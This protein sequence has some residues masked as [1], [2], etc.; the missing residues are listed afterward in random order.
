M[1]CQTTMRHF[2]FQNSI[3]VACFLVLLL[4][5]GSFLW[6]EPTDNNKR[7]VGGVGEEVVPVS[8]QPDVS[9]DNTRVA[10]VTNKGMLDFDIWTTKLDGTEQAPLLTWESSNEQHPDWSP[11]GARIAFSS[12]R[13]ADNSNI[14]LIDQHGMNPRQITSEAGDEDQP[15]FSPNGSLIAFTST[16]EGKSE[17]WIMGHD[18]SNQQQITHTQFPLQVN[19][20]AWSPDSSSLVFTLC[21]N[22]C[23]VFKVRRESPTD[24]TQLTFGE[25]YDRSPDWGNDGIVFASNRGGSEL[26]IMGQDGSNLRSVNPQTQMSVLDT[27]WNQFN[28]TI[29]FSKFEPSFEG[30]SSQIVTMLPDG[31]NEKQITDV[32]FVSFETLKNALSEMVIPNA[33]RKSL[34]EVIQE[35]EKL[36]LKGQKNAAR[37]VLKSIILIVTSQSGKKISTDNADS[38]ITIT[39]RLISTL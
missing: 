13:E 29:I 30:A 14:W 36:S 33:L 7:R 38:I 6:Y 25:F 26:W 21:D 12:D 1:P 23:N 31:T 4:M 28:N 5:I 11:D 22:T 9:P 16:Q 20:P 24:L 32:Y 18:G 35:A 10:F 2:N 15:R 34:A 3:L 19:D 8:E 17:L 27:K 39:N 37:K